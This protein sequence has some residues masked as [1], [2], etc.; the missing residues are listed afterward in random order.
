MR[1]AVW[2]KFRGIALPGLVSLLW[3]VGLAAAQSPPE[4]TQ[5]ILH[6]L[7][8]MAVEYPEFVQDGTVLDQA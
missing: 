3:I 7:D 2:R 1:I 8:Y 6:M 5:M 4:H